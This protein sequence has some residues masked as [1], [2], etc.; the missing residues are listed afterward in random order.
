MT[1]TTPTRDLHD[2]DAYATL[3]AVT[4]T[5]PPSAPPSTTATSPGHAPPSVERRARRR[6]AGVDVARALAITGMV[7]IHVAVVFAGELRHGEYVGWMTWM[8]YGKASTLFALVAGIGITLGSRRGSWGGNAAQLLWRA[9]WLAPLGLF[10]GMLGTPVA[11]ILQYYALW[12]VLAIPFLRAPTWLVSSV[13]GTWVL[14][15]PS[16]LV[17]AQ[18]THPEW[19]APRGSGAWLGTLGDVLL[20]GYYP[21]VSWLPVVLVGMVVGRLDLADRRVGG[22]LLA[23]GTATAFVT[24]NL[25]AALDRAIDLG[26]W[27][28]WF[29]TIG[30]ADTPPEMVAV[31]GVAVGVVGA[32]LLLAD[33]L[34]PLLE[35][36][37]RFGR[38][39]LT[40]YVGHIIYYAVARDTMVAASHEEVVSTTVTVALV[41]TVFATVWLQ[42][43][44]R[45][46]LEALDRGGFE[47]L[48]R[49]LFGGPGS[50]Q[51]ET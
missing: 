47:Y 41:A 48:V 34:H 15:G 23:V 30:H 42:V 21:T 16:I 7:A 13:A 33:L 10:L 18:V 25:A 51:Q 29:S 17:W 5:P 9:T 24:Y 6:I 31:T 49:P 20:T 26:R 11:V 43:F 50:R 46:P 35:P 2:A 19:Y 8:S 27:E 37:A 32:S 38:L 28:P 1:C 12:F 39:A 14:I 3:R 22:A 4:T 45:G 36:V 44:R 40:V